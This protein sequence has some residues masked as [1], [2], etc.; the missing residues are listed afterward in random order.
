[1][2]ACRCSDLSLFTFEKVCLTS[3][4]ETGAGSTTV[5][6]SNPK[7]R[8]TKMSSERHETNEELDCLVTVND[9]AHM[10]CDMVEEP[11]S[12]TENTKSTESRETKTF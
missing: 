4:Y 1:M 5:F 10:T 12:E 2:T 8:N 6:E 7:E 9:G 3:G 11:S